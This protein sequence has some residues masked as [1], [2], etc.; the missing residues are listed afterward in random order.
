MCVVLMQH[1]VSSH[2]DYAD[3]WVDN[4]EL[5][6]LIEENLRVLR[7]IE[8]S[9]LLIALQIEQEQID[10]TCLVTYLDQNVI[11]HGCSWIIATTH[12]L[13]RSTVDLVDAVLRVLQHFLIFSLIQQFTRGV[14]AAPL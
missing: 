3:F 1:L 10:A 14:K 9:Y 5:I 13:F 7:A 8:P 12:F 11:I 6:V 2:I 4:H